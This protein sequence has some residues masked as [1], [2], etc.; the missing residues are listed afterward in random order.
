M[1][2]LVVAA[3]LLVGFEQSVAAQTLLSVLGRDGVVR[4]VREER[5]G[6]VSELTAMTEVVPEVAAN[7][8]NSVADRASSVEVPA[9]A[10]PATAEA[11]LRVR[12]RLFLSNM[13][14]YLLAT[15]QK[16]TLDV[17][18]LTLYLDA[19]AQAK[20]CGEIPCQSGCADKRPCDFKC[21]SCAS[22]PR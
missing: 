15:T 8:D 9:P 5:T 16:V 6:F 4:V 1:R 14:T 22:Q 13:T 21:N 3:V 2:T 12:F 11:T 20:R 7:F 17:G 19:A 10:T 18:S